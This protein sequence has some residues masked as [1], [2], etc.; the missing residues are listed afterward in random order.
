MKTEHYEA[1][2]FD[3]LKTLFSKNATIIESVGLGISLLQVSDRIKELYIDKIYKK[4][5]FNEFLV[6]YE[7]C[8]FFWISH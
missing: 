7:Y 6:M 1:S 3:K 5:I 4:R 8:I 2:C